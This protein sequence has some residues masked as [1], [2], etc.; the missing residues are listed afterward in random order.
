MVYRFDS[1]FNGEVFGESVIDGSEPFLGLHYP[2]TDIPEQARNLYKKVHLRIIENVEAESAAIYSAKGNSTHTSLDLGNSILRSSSPIHLQYLKNMGVNATLTISIMIDQR[3]W[4]LVACHHHSPRYPS[5]SLREAA[6]ALTN[7][8]ST[9][10]HHWER[11]IDFA[12]VQEKEHIYQALISEAVKSKDLFSETMKVSYLL[13]LTNATGAALIRKD[14]VISYGKVPKDEDIYEINNWMKENHERVFQSNQFSNYYPKADLMKD[15][16]SG[17]LYYQ[18]DQ[19]SDSAILWFR[20]QM[21]EGKRWGGKPE[22]NKIL[23]GVLSPR[24]SF[25][26]WQEEVEGKSTPWKPFEIQAG[27]RFAAYVERE[28]FI[29]N[30]DLQ[31]ERY[32]KLTDQLQ[33]ANEELRQFN[34][35]SSHDMKE[36]LR[37]IRLFIDQI[38]IDGQDLGTSSI[39]FDRIDAAAQRMQKLIEDLLNYAGLSQPVGLQETDL[40][41]VVQDVA[42]ELGMSSAEIRCDHLPVIPAVDFQIRQL[43]TNLFSNA[44]KFQHIDRPLSIVISKESFTPEELEILFPEKGEDYIK[45][46]I[47]DNGIGFEPEYNEQIFELFQRLHGQKEFQGTGIGLAICKKIV[48][49]HHG[50]ISAEGKLNEGAGFVVVLKLAYR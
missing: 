24:K 47:Q 38:R 50:F 44:I 32:R 22:E 31:K 11:S 30:L 4:G 7:V 19:E 49:T 41:K 40:N 5:T 27:L 1:D 39:Y 37:K 10:L 15:I 25:E 29:R 34:W 2:H 20:Q 45:I 43:F 46:R 21:S 28:M 6:L 48:E 36:P 26:A 9:Q 17:I 3:L 14:M 18:L 16:A 23:E 35:I 12:A 8:L 13:G 33:Q 42:E